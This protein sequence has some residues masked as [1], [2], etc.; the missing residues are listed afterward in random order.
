MNNKFNL[1]CEVVKLTI[2]SGEQKANLSLGRMIILGVM[3]GAFISLGAAASNVAVHNIPD[4]GLA[5]ALS[6][7]IFPVGL[8]LVIFAGG[9]LFTGN[10]LMTMSLLDRKIKISQM[11]K[12]WTVVYASNFAGALII[13]ALIFFSK[14]LDFS[15][16]GLGAYTIKIAVDKTT[17]APFTGISS[18]ILCNILVC[19]AIILAT[20]AKDAIG[21]IFAVLFPIGAFV[22]CGFEHC[23]ANMFYIPMGIMAATNEK[24]VAAVEKLYG[25]TSEQCNE[26]IHLTGISSFMYVTIGNVIG[27]AILVGVFFHLAHRQKDK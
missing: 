24:Y 13:A 10:C 26:L 11:L 12:N 2:E 18:G 15:D 17:I 5:K 4:V 9:E 7:V 27:G 14:Q 22:I 20:A 8:I 25:I 19:F 6:G 16:G 3:A 23:V 1:P 21:K